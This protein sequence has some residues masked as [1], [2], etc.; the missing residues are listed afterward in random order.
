MNKSPWRSSQLS[1]NKF[2]NKLQLRKVT[3]CMAPPSYP[4]ALPQVFMANKI[5]SS[6]SS[7]V[8]TKSSS[9]SSSTAT[10][11]TGFPVFVFPTSLNF[12]VDDTLSHKQC[13]SIYN[14]Y[15][16]LVKFKGKLINCFFLFFVV[17]LIRIIPLYKIRL[18]SEIE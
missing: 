5:P 17:I 16:F 10:T 9:S 14:P 18:L 12:Y 13:L 4:S 6:M 7:S 2:G 8:N 1:N 3:D 15:D 11:N